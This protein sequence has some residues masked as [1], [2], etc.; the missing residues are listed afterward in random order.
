MTAP[1]LLACIVAALLLQLAVGIGVAVWR[2][3]GSAADRPAAAQTGPADNPSAAWSGWRE[4]RVARREFEDGAHTQCS[5]HLEPVDGAALPP[6]KPGQFLTFSLKVSGEHAI[7]RC[8][9]LSDRPDTGRYRITVKRLPA[10]PGRSDVPPGVASS[11]FHDRV[12]EGDVLRVRAP[13]GRFCIDPDPD[14][15]VVLVAGGIGI[16]PLLSMLRWCLAEQ[17]GRTVHLY[18][19]VRG[20]DEHAFRQPL[21]ALA[22]S[23]PRFHLNVIYSRPGPNDVL[24]RDYHHA[25][26]VDAGLLRRTLPEGRHQFY[27]CGPAALMESLIPALSRSGVPERDIHHE[28]FGPASVPAARARQALRPGIATPLEVRFRRSGRT[29]AWDGQD[30]NLL[31]FAERNGVRIPS[32]CRAGSCGSCETKLVSGTVHYAQVPDH[33][34]AANHCLLCVGTPASALVLEA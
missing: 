28:A 31:E 4:F 11:H 18:Y 2:R 17:P 15:P 14:V 33:E 1:L 13:S 24:G 20:G 7:I 12:H 21:E 26:H 10:P 6:F 3:G 23:H 29:L 19:G 34:V 9:S 5:F 30:K 8:Y 16:T 32:G 27:V 22:R 25:G